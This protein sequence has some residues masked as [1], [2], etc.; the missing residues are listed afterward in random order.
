LRDCCLQKR[1]QI[2]DVNWL[3]Q[4]STMTVYITDVNIIGVNQA[5]Q[6]IQNRLDDVVDVGCVGGS[7]I[8]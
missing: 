5:N 8:D 1:R 3:R 2:S 6:R 4:I 7:E